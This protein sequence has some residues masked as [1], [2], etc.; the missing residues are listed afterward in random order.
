V[1]G[2]VFLSLV[3]WTAQRL[4]NIE[5]FPYSVVVSLHRLVVGFIALFCIGKQNFKTT[6]LLG[7]V[8]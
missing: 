1:R 2:V 8:Y 3:A 7:L 5:K 6:L 4:K